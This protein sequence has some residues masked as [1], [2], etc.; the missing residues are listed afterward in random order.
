M[1]IRSWGPPALYHNYMAR[2]Q[3]QTREVG[4][5]L[6]VA[7]ILMIVLVFFRKAR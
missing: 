4:T 7:V 5:W 3:E 6:Y 1:S 2:W